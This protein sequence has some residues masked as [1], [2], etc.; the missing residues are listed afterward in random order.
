MIPSV[1]ISCCITQ[2]PEGEAIFFNRSKF[3]LVHKDAVVLREYVQ[4]SPDCRDLLSLHPLILENLLKRH[5][6]LQTVFLRCTEC[7]SRF[8]LVANTHLYFHPMGDHIRLL[9]VEIS[10]RYLANTL[11]SLGE[12][13]SK[14][15]HIAVV[16]CGDFNSCPCT[17]AYDYL[18]NG[19]VSRDHPEW[20]LY[21][22]TEVPQCSCNHR[23]LNI[24]HE[25]GEHQIES[26][27]TSDT[28]EEPTA[29][30]DLKHSFNF[31]NSCGT[32]CATNVTL[33]WTGVIDYIFID[34]SSLNTQRV[35]PFPPAEQLTEHVA[36]PS[37]NFPSDHIAL[38]TDLAWRTH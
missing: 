7:P 3:S 20:Q 6:I 27:S 24:I 21:R 19:K 9:Q 17:A 15:A 12:R 25:D 30:L 34:A 13:V 11:Q 23:S 28:S 38:V 2:T 18:L 10:L 26:Y 5:N 29:G 16:F 1:S 8:L 33:G 31:S 35:V 4:Q 22:M 32:R 36:L 37:I 14:D